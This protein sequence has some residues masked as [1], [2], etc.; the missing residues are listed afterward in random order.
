MFN[1]ILNTILRDHCKEKFQ[2]YRRFN[3][4]KNLTFSKSEFLQFLRT[5]VFLLFHLLHDVKSSSKKAIVEL[6]KS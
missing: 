2:D 1:K 3:H 5:K 4:E 6:S